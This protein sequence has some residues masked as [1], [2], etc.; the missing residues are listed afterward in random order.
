M[1]A[2]HF[3][4]GVTGLERQ[5]RQSMTGLR[6]NGW[7][8]LAPRCRHDGPI[9]GDGSQGQSRPHPPLSAAPTVPSI[10]QEWKGLLAHEFDH[11]P[12]ADWSLVVVNS[13]EVG[14]E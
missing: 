9:P 13:L 14:N 5:W 8:P 11:S 2:A 7:S 6:T 10:G 12:I 3:L 4:G 1:S